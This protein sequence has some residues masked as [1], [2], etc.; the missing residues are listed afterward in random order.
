MSRLI[1]WKQCDD[2]AFRSFCKLIRFFYKLFS[3]YYVHSGSLVVGD[4][5]S[6][7]SDHGGHMHAY[8]RSS[9]GTG[10]A[11]TSSCIDSAVIDMLKREAVSVMREYEQVFGAHDITINAHH[12]IHLPEVLRLFGTLELVWCFPFERANK[13]LAQT[14]KHSTVSPEIR[15][16][17]WARSQFALTVMTVRH[18]QE[19]MSILPEEGQQQ[20]HEQL[21]RDSD[22]L[23]RY[24]QVMSVSAAH[25]GDSGSVTMN[26]DV[27]DLDEHDSDS[28]E[29]RA[30][31]FP[32]L[33]YIIISVFISFFDSH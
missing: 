9:R 1:L 24:M 31:V 16:V 7:S 27:A 30:E 22:L 5:R 33:Q 17:D 8:R 18:H 20:F 14:A 23:D 13:D 28:A 26:C 29:V 19:R 15:M 2:N 21:S 12:V 10:S 11:A 32:Y 25:R 3:C 4:D 6:N